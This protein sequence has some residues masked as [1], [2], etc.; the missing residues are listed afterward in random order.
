[1]TSKG[2][3]GAA[4]RVAYVLAKTAFLFGL[5]AWSYV[6]AIQ[7]THPRLLYGP[8]TEWLWIRL[9]YFGE[10]AFIMSIV[11]YLILKFWETEK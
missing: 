1:M 8:L 2:G 11:A 7:L 3:K 6:V 4:D 10:V 5:L 9:D